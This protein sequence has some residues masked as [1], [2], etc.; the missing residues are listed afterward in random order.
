LD[1]DE[2]LLANAFVVAK[3]IGTGGIREPVVQTIVNNYESLRPYFRTIYAS[4]KGVDGIN[5]LLATMPEP[6]LAEGA[7]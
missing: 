7:L 1:S 6:A 3:G 5:A 2:I 4:E